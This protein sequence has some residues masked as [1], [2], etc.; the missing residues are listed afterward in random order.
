MGFDP[1]LR[2][3]PSRSWHLRHPA[4]VS[5]PP[6]LEKGQEVSP[7]EEAHVFHLATEAVLPSFI[8]LLYC[9]TLTGEGVERLIS[10]YFCR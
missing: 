1:L 4:S 3:P 9:P 7:D 10:S 5:L 2:P 6:L 8:A